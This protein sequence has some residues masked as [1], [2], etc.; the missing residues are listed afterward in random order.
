M[1]RRDYKK[2][3]ARDRDG[4][5][6]GTE[7][8]REWDDADLQREFGMYQDMALRSVPGASEYGEG[9]RRGS[10]ATGRAGSGS[11]SVDGEE[12]VTRRDF[13]K[14]EGEQ[15]DERKGGKSDE[16]WWL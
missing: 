4:N 9:D 3:F 7:P 12:G 6:A 15:R 16:E 2:Y 13:E 14:G 11:G 5:Y 1:P 10:A 8:E